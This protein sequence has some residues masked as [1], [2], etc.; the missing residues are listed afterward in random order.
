MPSRTENIGKS[1]SRYPTRDTTYPED[2]HTLGRLRMRHDNGFEASVHAHDQY[3]GTWNRRPGTPDT[4][5]AI[6]STDI[7][8]TAQQSFDT[9]T[10]HNNIGVEYFGRRDVTGYDARGSV[11]NRTYSLQDASEDSWSLFAL[12]DWQLTP[13]FALELGGRHTAVEQEQARANSDNSDTA[14]T[15]GAAWIPNAASRWTV[16]LATGYR[17]P[18][19][20]ERFFTGVTAQGGIVG[21]PSL[22]AEHSFGIDFG[23]AWQS[24]DWGTELHAWHMDVDDLIQLFDISPDVNGYMNVGEAKLYGFEAALVWTPI[25]DFSLRAT[26]AVVRGENQQSGDELYGIAPVTV[27]LEAKYNFADFTLGG[28]YSHR[29]RVTHPGFEEVE[30]DAVDVFDAELRYRINPQLDLQFYLRNAF[31]ENYYATADELST[32]AQERSIGFNFTWIAR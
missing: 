23:Y 9:G 16:N 25:S 4:F 19:L 7:G 27:T 18:T 26:G 29:R 1:N 31:N 32:L 15:A 8:A 22:G 5:A 12:T 20:E 3:L 6:S 13:E 21:N 30:R 24:G 2:S 28:H 17:F 14:F 10:L 11:H